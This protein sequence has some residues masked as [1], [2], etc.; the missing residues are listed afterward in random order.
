M[1]LNLIMG[2][3]ELMTIEAFETLKGA[4][5]M[6]K[7]ALLPRSHVRF[8]VLSPQDGRV[9]FANIMSENQIS[10]ALFLSLSILLVRCKHFRPLLFR[11]YLLLL[12]V[13]TVE[14]QIHK[15]VWDFQSV[16]YGAVTKS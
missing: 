12:Q 3:S 15:A 1:K 8:R 6:L 7:K 13:M 11:I 5:T 9:S 4:K 10:Q 2:Q 14:E 16:I